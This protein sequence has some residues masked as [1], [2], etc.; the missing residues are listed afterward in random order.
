MAIELK[1]EFEW[2]LAHQGELVAKHLG[3]VLVIRDQQVIGVYETEEEALFAAKAR[4]QLG[5][6]IIQKCT[7]GTDDTSMAFHSRVSFA[8]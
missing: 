8:V 6:F 5:T 2:Y 3:K 1:K 7:P 4:Y